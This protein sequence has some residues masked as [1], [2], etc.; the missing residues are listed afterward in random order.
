MAHEIVVFRPGALGDTL[1]TCD[2]LQVLRYRYPDASIELVGNAPAGAL[3]R[4]AGLVD[5][6][7]SFDS[8]DVLGLFRNAPILSPRWRSVAIA[9]VWLAS[10]GPIAAALREAGV[11][12]VVA[13]HPEP[14]QPHVHVADH[15]VATLNALRRDRLQIPGPLPQ[16]KLCAM[17]R[18]NASQPVIFLH[19]GSG[20]PKKNWPAREFAAVARALVA[21]RQ[22]LV[23]LCGPADEAALGDLAVEM[24]EDL[25]PVLT[26]PDLL[27]LADA[28][29]ACSLL[30][31]NDS[32]VSHLSARLAVPTVAVF[33]VTDPRCWAPRGPSVVVVGGSGRWPSAADVLVAVDRIVPGL[34]GAAGAPLEQDTNRE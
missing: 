7:T 20:S 24:G 14:V 17:A 16:V 34:V 29:V 19:P 32:G 31:G 25:P 9:V 15:L 12:E 13:A 8:S 4:D 6:V 5:R 3:L 26:P 33:G 23:V 2:A 21:H 22:P 18:G 30:I 11:L 27:S 1:L 10:P 28:L